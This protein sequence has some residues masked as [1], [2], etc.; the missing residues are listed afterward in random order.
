MTRL[1][2]HFVLAY[3]SLMVALLLI[4]IRGMSSAAASSIDVCR[5]FQYRFDYNAPTA[6]CSAAENVLSF[7]WAIANAIVRLRHSL[8]RR[9][10]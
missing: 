4:V 9:I 10:H 7:F 2:A 5:S 6:R 1:R 3:R 8:W